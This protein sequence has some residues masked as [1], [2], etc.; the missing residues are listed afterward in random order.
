MIT[1]EEYKKF[2]KEMERIA[3]ALK[4]WDSPKLN[5]LANEMLDRSWDI[6]MTLI[7]KEEIR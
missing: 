7:Q 4:E 3:W 5:E 6:G 1:F 2:D